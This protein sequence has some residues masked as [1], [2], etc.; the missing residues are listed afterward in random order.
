M[1]VNLNQLRAFYL[2][3]RYTSMAAAA[4]KLHVSPPAITMQIKKFEQWLGFPLF[5]RNRPTLV[6][7]G[8]GETLYALAKT[9]FENVEHLEKHLEE[10]VGNRECELLFGTYHIPARYVMPHILAH[11][12]R[13]CPRLRLRMTLGTQEESLARLRRRD[14]DVALLV[15]PPSLPKIKTVL[16][17]REN[18]PLVVTAGS[19]LC[20]REVIGVRELGSLPLILQQRGTGFVQAV[21]E[22]L[23]QHG[24]APCIAMEDISSDIVKQFLLQDEG[25]AF[26]TRFAIQKELDEGT[27][28]EIRIAEGGPTIEFSLAYL[29][30]QYLSPGLQQFLDSLSGFSVQHLVA[31][32]S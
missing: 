10:M 19:A 12:R 29:D 20:K 17:C 28:Q 24:V 16:L 22:Y 4:N 15:S 23:H 30:Q 5:S 32:P 21:R 25:A 7:T 2:A 9:V 11:V 18:V 31:Y 3:A 13:T 27:L 1:Y 26:I 8:Q 14:L 6:L